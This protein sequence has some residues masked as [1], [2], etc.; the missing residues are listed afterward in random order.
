[1]AVTRVR[2]LREGDVVRVATHPASLRDWTTI[3][4]ITRLANWLTVVSEDGV[5]AD[6]H[7]DR[8]V[9]VRKP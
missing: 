7:Q 4:K 6:L 2:Y 1:M 9:E 5:I 3:V 8:E